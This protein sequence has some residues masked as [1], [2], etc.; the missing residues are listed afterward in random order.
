MSKSIDS[1][2]TDAAKKVYEKSVETYSKLEKT[3]YEFISELDEDQHKEYIGKITDTWNNIN[4]MEMN[5]QKHHS[6][7]NTTKNF[8]TKGNNN[9][10]ATALSTADNSTTNN[11]INSRAIVQQQTIINRN[12]H[13]K[14]QETINSALSES[15]NSF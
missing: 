9:T 10:T 7:E 12:L 11:N 13:N 8:N 2:N 5:I 3:N 1:G 15:L 14:N 4:D 6:E